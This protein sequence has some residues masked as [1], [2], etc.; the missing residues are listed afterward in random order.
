VIKLVFC[1]IKTLNL[2]IF[3]KKF[4]IYMANEKFI[5]L[6][7]EQNW[8]QE[9]YEKLKIGDLQSN[10]GIATL[11]TFKEVVFKELDPTFYAVVGNFYDRQN[12]L[13][14]LIRNCLANPNI[15]YI[16]IVGNDKAKSKEVL[17]NFFEKGV[18]EG[19]VFGT[20]TKIPKEIPL[21]EIEKLR[22]NVKIFDL[23][24]KIKNFE[25]PKEYSKIIKEFIL[26]LEK[27]EPYAEPKL[28]PKPKLNVDNY[29][30]EQAGF[31]VRGKK[32]GET[33]LKILRNIFDYGKITKMKENDS[34]Y[35]REC[36]N[37][38]AVVE[39]EDPDEPKIEPYFRF[40][41]K[42]LKEY[43]EEICSPKIPNGTIYT[44]GSR[45]RAWQGKDGEII[46]QIADMIEYL[47]K[48]IYR[49]SA[50]AITWIVE[51][52]LTRRYKNKDKNSPCIILVQPNIQEG[53]LHLTAYIR[54]NDMFRAWPLN[55]FGLRK[56]QKIIVSSLGVEMGS[57]TTISNSAHI[58]QDN[59]NETKEL[60][61][62]YGKVTNCF[63]DP[64]GYYII[65]LE[66]GKIKVQ[67]LSVE[68]R[69]LKN[70][71][72]K[73]ARAISDEINSSQHPLDSYHSSYLGEELMKAEIALSLGIEYTQDLPLD[74]KNKG[75]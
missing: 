58:Y 52:E 34:T 12:G 53:V 16:L 29:P 60:L 14:P 51:D 70:Y 56:L 47:K 59:W 37:F 69:L 18:F 17:V 10:V 23:T 45:M 31:L 11:W 74:L 25:E 7:K 9:F 43:Y 5:S 72:G 63:Y 65:R 46:D 20:E 36:I 71:E 66:E 6:L 30:A 4:L 26:N 64:R 27:K 39:D 49:K 38:M 3:S 55:A 42:Y 73:T 54:S 28:F 40:D 61:E 48:D 67:H 1:V 50:L 68:G 75:L 41:E 2:Y 32:V 62:K 44:Y 8:P 57:L 33:W 13:E 24:N 35:V 22:K 15:R 21:E 19:K